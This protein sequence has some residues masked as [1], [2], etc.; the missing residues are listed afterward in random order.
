MSTNCTTF[1][2]TDFKRSCW[3]ILPT[4]YRSVS[5]AVG[6]TMDV[7]EWVAGIVQ[8]GPST[9]LK[10]R[11]LWSIARLIP[12]D[13]VTVILLMALCEFSFVSMSVK[14]FLPLLIVV[15]G[16]RHWINP[17][18]PTVHVMHQQFNIQQLY[19]LPTLYLCVLYLSE[20]KQRLVPLTE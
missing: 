12:Y 3:R 2:S 8:F 1:R 19:V 14:Y 10:P 4:A 5:S 9:G 13:S 20:N 18:K 15:G 6:V 17:L 11:S 16:N 7:R